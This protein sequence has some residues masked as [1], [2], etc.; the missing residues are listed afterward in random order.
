MSESD[1]N[2]RISNVAQKKTKT[3]SKKMSQYFRPSEVDN[4]KLGELLHKVLPEQERYKIN[5]ISCETSKRSLVMP[6]SK[7]AEDLGSAIVAVSNEDSVNKPDVLQSKNS[8]KQ[9]ASAEQNTNTNPN[10]ITEKA[11]MMIANRAQAMVRKQRRAKCKQCNMTI[12]F[13]PDMKIGP[14]NF[15]NEK[16]GKFSDFYQILTRLGEGGYGQ[17]FKVVH[18]KSQLVRAMKSNPLNLLSDPQ[19]QS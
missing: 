2:N 1:L 9:T 13:I 5:I 12:A 11:F 19:K 8:L 7:S 10:P 4:Q 3:L 18:K 17:V 15:I 16:T 6:K 14:E